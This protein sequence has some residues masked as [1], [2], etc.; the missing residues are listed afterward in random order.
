[1]V[2]REVVAMVD[3]MGTIAPG[4][5]VGTIKVTGDVTF[6]P[7]SVLE[8]AAVLRDLFMLKGDKELSFG[9]R[10]MLDTARNL[11][12]KQFKVAGYDIDAARMAELDEFG[13]Q[14]MN[15]TGDVA[16]FAD[17]VITSLPSAASVGAVVEELLQA[18]KPGQ[19]VIECSTLSVEDKIAAHE[20][21]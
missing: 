8:I 9:E 15:S 12:Q 11:L 19:V 3:H 14:A 5:S 2:A 10:K 1:M 20:A 4:N 21:L 13:L 16:K 18:D 17:V 6:A 7:G